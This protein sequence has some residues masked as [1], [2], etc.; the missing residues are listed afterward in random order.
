MI[1]SFLKNHWGIILSGLIL[2][3]LIS[4]PLI[5]FPWRAGEAYKGINI[6]HGFND[7]EYLMRGKDALEGHGLGNPA[8]REGKDKPDYYF[9]INEYALVLP[10]RALGLADRVNIATLYGVYNFIGVFLLI[11]LIYFFTLRLKRDKLLALTASLFVVGGYTIVVWHTLFYPE[12]NIYGRA[13]Y[14]Y[15][16]SLAFFSYLILL[17]RALKSAALKHSLYAG[18]VFGLL[19]YV[20]FF[21][22]TFALAFNLILF[23]LFMFSRN[24]DS[25]KKVLIIS[26]L[27][28]M[29]GAYNLF[30]LW[31]FV[32]SPAGGQFAYFSSA[33][34][35]HSPVFTKLGLAAL[36]LYVLYFVLNRRFNKKDENEILILA[37][38]LAGWVAL[39]QQVITGRTIQ[40]NHYY[41][42][43]VTPLSILFAIYIFWSWI[44]NQKFKALAS[45]ALMV[46]VFV[47][48]AVG[49]YK[50]V[51][52][53]WEG[54]IYEQNYAP[55]I[56]AL[57]K[58]KTPTVILAAD[59]NELQSLFAIYTP[60]DLFWHS[61]ATYNDIPL[62]R[63]E[64]AFFV[65]TYLNKEA[66]DDFIG[67]APR[68]EI[69]KYIEGYNSSL[70][71]DEYRLANL[72]KKYDQLRAKPAGIEKLLAKYGVR[73]IVWDKNKHPEWDLSSIKNLKEAAVFNNIYLY[74]IEN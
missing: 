22:W 26:G 21:G 44:P 29:L 24:W 14:P 35:S 47:N 53:T 64:D 60:H 54:R 57:N 62:E 45:A 17:H 30:R 73:Y 49:Q 65:Y 59:D 66:R 74:K 2:T 6:H 25:A 61:F 70:N 9:T 38:I 67:W 40:F 33:A 23:C 72:S 4:S 19:F 36:L 42:Y 41:W 12:L 69:Y 7:H 8:M 15:L 52:I 27:G 18:A 39:N 10:V 63:F 31:T 11:L 55:I 50:S 20:A 48:T 16:I 37:F 51:L 32:S 46:L 1:S 71:N 28:I 34:F 5:V 58:N 13:M 68:S 3:A 43:F 56:N